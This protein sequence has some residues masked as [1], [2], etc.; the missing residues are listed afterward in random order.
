MKS[1]DAKKTEDQP[2]NSSTETFQ[3]IKAAP[4]TVA[5]DETRGFKICTPPECAKQA[6]DVLKRVPERDRELWDRRLTLSCVERILSSPM[7]DDETKEFYWNI[8]RKLKEQ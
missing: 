6:A 8:Q 3:V 1:T 2:V 7:V 4:F 5:L